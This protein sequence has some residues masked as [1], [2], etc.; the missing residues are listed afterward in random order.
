[1]YDVSQIK[2]SNIVCE[3]LPVLFRAIATAVL[4]S[5]VIFFKE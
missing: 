1:M 3:V 4:I 2:L 5:S